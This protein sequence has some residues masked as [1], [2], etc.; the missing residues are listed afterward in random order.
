MASLYEKEY[1]INVQIQ[2][3]GSLEELYNKMIP[4]FKE[5][6]KNPYAWMGMFYQYYM[7]NGSTTLGTLENGKYPSFTAISVEKFLKEHPKESI[8]KLLFF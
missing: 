1:K 8:A 6:G 5:Q 3:M 7:Q 2:R 4:I